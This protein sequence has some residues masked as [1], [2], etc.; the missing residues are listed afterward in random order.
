MIGNP[1]LNK[2]MS[3][4]LMCHDRFVINWLFTKDHAG[5]TIISDNQGDFLINKLCK[6]RHTFDKFKAF[7]T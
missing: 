4:K 3:K 5:S 2:V 1:Y 7:R 6:Y